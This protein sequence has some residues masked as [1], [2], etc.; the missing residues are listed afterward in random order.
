M[1]FCIL[2]QIVFCST[3]APPGINVGPEHGGNPSRQCTPA[4]KQS[5]KEKPR[6]EKP[7]PS[8]HSSPCPKRS[9]VF[10]SDAHL[11]E[12]APGGL[13]WLS[14][15]GE[16]GGGGG[17]AAAGGGSSTG[18]SRGGPGAR[19]Y[20]T[21][22]ALSDGRLLMFGGRVLHLHVLWSAHTCFNELLRSCEANA[23]FSCQPLTLLLLSADVSDWVLTS[24]VF[25]NY[26]F[27]GSG[28]T[29][30]HTC[31]P[32]PAPRHTHAAGGNGKEMFADAWWLDL[33]LLP[34]AQLLQSRQRPPP[35]PPLAA[36]DASPKAALP[37]LGSPTKPSPAAAPAQQVA[38]PLYRR[39]NKTLNP[40]GTCIVSF[41]V[42]VP[43]HP[44][45][46]SSRAGIACTAP[47]DVSHSLS[48]VAAVGSD[49]GI[50]GWQ[51]GELDVYRADLL[52]IA[53]VPISAAVSAP[54]LGPTQGWGLPS[55]DVMPAH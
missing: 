51:R 32:S 5:R 45:N 49:G 20:H 48:I 1:L 2:Q 4:A 50:F 11:L 12:A 40:N 30:P 6:K 52:V 55:R 18:S 23:V 15:T 29:S 21:L 41:R 42:H 43:R 46:K 47:H 13:R 54:I 8:T 26:S 19:E 35:P 17:D 9:D 44:S 16:A 39:A 34:Q 24:G 3:A 22:T 36:A 53:P 27:Q 31:A 7:R 38:F 33:Q 14:L 28:V 10:H 25:F 37:A